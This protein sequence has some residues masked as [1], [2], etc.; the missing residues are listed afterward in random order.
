MS[1]SE[2]Q[3]LSSPAYT[4]E[5]ASQTIYDA[6]TDA[7]AHQRAFSLT[8][9]EAIVVIEH[10]LRELVEIDAAYELLQVTGG[11]EMRMSAYIAGRISQL[12]DSGH[13]TLNEAKA[14]Y[15]RERQRR[16]LDHDPER[17]KH[18]AARGQFTLMFNLSEHVLD[19]FEEWI[20]LQKA[21]GVAVDAEFQFGPHTFEP[22]RY[23]ITDMRRW[24]LPD[25]D[26]RWKSEVTYALTGPSDSFPSMNLKSELHKHVGEWDQSGHCWWDRD[27]GDD[28]LP[29]HFDAY[30]AAEDHAAVVRL[31]PTTNENAEFDWAMI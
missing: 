10:Y 14:L 16:G 8:R 9:F 11:S 22:G 23:L 12:V 3:R 27:F 20:E 5:K 24:S 28:E 31:S 25:S 26:P 6:V 21:G 13:V 2:V 15:S 7:G 29:D 30:T 18:E 19:R 17:R 1:K 4:C